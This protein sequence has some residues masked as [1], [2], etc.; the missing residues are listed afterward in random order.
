[1]AAAPPVVRDLGVSVVPLLV[2]ACAYNA[3]LAF[4]IAHGVALGLPAVIAVEFLILAA[5]GAM[6]LRSGRRPLDSIGFLVLAMFVIDGLAVSLVSASPFIDMVRNGAIIALF[7][8]LGGRVGEKQL[9]QAFFACTLLVLI[10]LLVEI[11]DVG[12]YAKQF[13]PALYFERTRGVAQFDF[14]DSGLFRNALGFD[15]RFSLSNLFGHRTAS[16]FLEQVSLANYASVL[17]IYLVAMWR[18]LAPGQ[19]LFY[20]AVVA[21]ILVSNNSRTGLAL[22]LVAPLIYWAAPR[23]NRF[24]PA[25]IMPLILVMAVALVLLLPPSVEDD[26]SGRVGLAMATLGKVDVLALFGGRAPSASEFLDSGYTYLIYSTSVV[27]LLLFW[28][29]VALILAV[30][31]VAARRAAIALGLYIFM[32][33]LVSGNAIFSI[34]TAALLW[35]LVGFLRRDVGDEPQATRPSENVPS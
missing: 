21:L 16:L 11:V 2:A 4:A 22:V 19:R 33:L 8:L 13:A 6:I 28:S 3:M 26:M 20:I 9:K 14:D 23:L 12:L 30:P 18:R 7:L 35:L 15:G 27:G 32:N 34:K 5:T 25:A 24:V 10:V 29:F 1:M 31:G 17:I